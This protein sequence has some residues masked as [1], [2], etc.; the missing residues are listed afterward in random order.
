MLLLVFGLLAGNAMVVHALLV[1]MRVVVRLAAVWPVVRLCV[2]S[3][4]RLVVLVVVEVWHS[5]VLLVVL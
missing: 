4:L 2:V 3:V 1:E 5:W